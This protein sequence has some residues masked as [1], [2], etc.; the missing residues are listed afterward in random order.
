MLDTRRPEVRRRLGIGGRFYRFGRWVPLDPSV[1]RGLRR[2]SR[3]R[4]GEPMSEFAHRMLLEVKWSRS[5]GQ[6]HDSCVF[7]ETASATVAT[8]AGARGDA[9][10]SLRYGR[11][12]A[13]WSAGR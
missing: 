12:A 11:S 13:A 8:P 7:G 6:N 9:R 10:P 3:R 1:R 4:G 2:A 5:Q